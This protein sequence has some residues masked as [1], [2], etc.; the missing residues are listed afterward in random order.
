MAHPPTAAAPIPFVWHPRTRRHVPSAEIWLGVRTPGTEVVERV[1]VIREALIR[2]GHPEVTAGDPDPEAL[3]AVHSPGLIE[4]LRT[5]HDAW[6]V[7][8]YPT[9]PGQDRVVPYVFPTEA[10]LGGLPVRRPTA[11]H[12]RAGQYCYDTMTLI[13][14]GT[15][16]AVEA[17]AGAALTAVDLVATRGVEDRRGSDGGRGTRRPRDAPPWRTPCAARPGTTQRGGVRRL[18]LPEQRRHRRRRAAG[19]GRPRVAVL[20]IDAHHGN[21]TQAIFYNRGDVFYGSVHVDP[22]AGWFP[23]F[24]GFADETGPWRGLGAN[25]NIP[26]PPRAGDD[27]WLTAVEQLVEAP[28]FG[29]DALVVS[30][31]VDAAIDDPESPLRVTRDGCGPPGSCSAAWACRRWPCRRAA[32]TSRP[33]ARWSPRPWPGWPRAPRLP[34]CRARLSP[35]RYSTSSSSRASQLARRS[36]GTSNSGFRSTNVTSCPASHSR[37]TSSSPRRATS[38]SMPRSVS[39]TSGPYA[40]AWSMRPAAPPR[41]GAATRPTARSWRSG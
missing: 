30:L 16:D 23:H 4:H 10:M 35:S 29:A 21:G 25:L 39:Y 24:I 26:L 36:T 12:A 20:D 38:S 41:G 19:P 22:G 18:V 9:D 31:G 37:V 3:L 15:W 33:S 6:V 28:A 14:P 1:N 40:N 5:I 34:R 2:A 13:G 27:R 8:G 7:G 32:T 17:A 11:A